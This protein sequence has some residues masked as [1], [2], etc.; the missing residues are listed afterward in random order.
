MLSYLSCSIGYPS[1]KIARV[2][3]KNFFRN[4]APF[5]GTS[6]EGA[7]RKSEKNNVNTYKIVDS[8]LR[9]NDAFL[10][11]VYF[12][13]KLYTFSDGKHGDI[14]KRRIAGAVLLYRLLYS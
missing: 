11:L 7:L 8:R 2:S 6:K 14:V 10:L 5:G 13:Q 9:G 4:G 3:D 1:L 12:E